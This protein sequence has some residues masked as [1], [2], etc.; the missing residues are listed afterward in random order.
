MTNQ[1]RELW[2][3]HWHLAHMKTYG[4]PIQELGMSHHTEHESDYTRARDCGV[5]NISFPRGD[6][7]L[8]Y[9]LLKD[10]EWSAMRGAYQT[11][12]FAE[13]AQC[14]ACPSC[15]GVMPDAFMASDFPAS[16]NGH[17]SDCRLLSSLLTL[18]SA[19]GAIE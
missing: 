6:L 13:P 17:A 18:R 4:Q 15:Y 12:P 14:A 5:E 16:L 8:L 3:A 10:L 1:E 11:A 7:G 2:A 9:Q 19:L